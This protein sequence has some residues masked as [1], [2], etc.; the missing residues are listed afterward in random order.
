MNEIETW[1]DELLKMI[2][3]TAVLILTRLSRIRREILLE[4]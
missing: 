1:A 3:H 4:V 2:S